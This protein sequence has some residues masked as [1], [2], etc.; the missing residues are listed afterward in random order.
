MDKVTLRGGTINK[1]KTEAKKVKEVLHNVYRNGELGLSLD[2]II[3]VIG[4]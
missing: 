2:I 1:E 4:T 3:I